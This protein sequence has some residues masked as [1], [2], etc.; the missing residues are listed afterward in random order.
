[1]RALALARVGDLASPP[2]QG[3]DRQVLFGREAESAAVEGLIARAGSSRSG[4]LVI[5][6]EP[7]VGKSA[8][9]GH[10]IEHAT[11]MRVLRAGGIE[12]E[13]ELAFAALH[14]LVRPVLDRVGRLAEPQAAALAR[15]ARAVAGFRRATAS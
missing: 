6:G 9:L 2:G 8:L 11:G 3:Y 13:S 4:A 1:M 7:G 14:Q 12:A 5:R 15:C 10:A